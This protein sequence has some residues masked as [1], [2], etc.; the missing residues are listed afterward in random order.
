MAQARHPYASRT[1]AFATMH[2]KE[3]VVAPA[4]MSTPGLIVTSPPGVDTDQLGTFSGEI[5]RDGTMLDVAMRKARLGMR[6]AGV[7]LGLASEGS[8]GPHPAI[9]YIPAGMELLVFVDDES[10]I[11]VAESLIAEKTNYDHLVVSPGEASDGFLQRIGFPTHGLIVR[12]N[13]GEV[14]SALAKGIVDPDRLRRAI[15]AAAAV[16]SDGRARME[17]DMRA[18]FNP[19]RMRSLAIL[20]E[21][22]AQRLA[23]QCPACGA[24]G[25]G[26]TGSRAGLLCEACGAP[27]EL[28]V[29]ERLGCPACDYTEERLRGDGLQRAPAQH[30][31]LCNP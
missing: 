11:V 4:L 2:R 20:A 26:R 25:F 19:T 9:P 3:Q 10:G 22:L 23:R 15:E 24:P 8:F 30:C 17:T 16:S 12:P 31:P 21:R 18:H 7:P 13:E 6:A 14:A 5:P 27:T 1:A 28:V 29:A